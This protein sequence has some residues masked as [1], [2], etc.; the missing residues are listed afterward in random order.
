MV[1]YQYI[2]LLYYRIYNRWRVGLRIRFIFLKRV[3]SKCVKCENKITLID[4]LVTYIHTHTLKK[5]HRE[6]TAKIRI[7]K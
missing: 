2:L 4:V 7:S 3:L 1:P 5:K 6:R